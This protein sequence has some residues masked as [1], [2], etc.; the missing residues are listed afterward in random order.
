MNMYVSNLGFHASDA[1]L[2]ELFNPFG[3]VSSAKVI[4]D[5]TSGRSRGFGFVEMISALEA[6]NAME[7]LDGKEVDGKRISVW[8]AKEREDR[9][10][11]RR[12]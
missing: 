12:W 3:K 11:K 6:A 4:M 7:T 2:R 5:R 1:D 9:S 10:D 8:A